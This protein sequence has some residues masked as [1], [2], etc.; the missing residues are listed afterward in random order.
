VTE[1]RGR[2]RNPELLPVTRELVAEVERLSGLPV[3]IEPRAELR[4]KARAAYAVSDPDR[5]RHL[6]LYDPQ[7]ERFLDHMVAHECGHIV[8]YCAASPDDA[9]ILVQNPHDANY[10]RL[11]PELADLIERGMPDRFIQELLPLWLHGSLAQLQNIPADIHIERW[12][13]REFPDLRQ[14]QLDSIGDQADDYLQALAPDVRE[15]TPPSVWLAGNAMNYALLKTMGELFE[16]PEFYEP[17]DEVPKVV[18]LGEILLDEERR[19]EDT[20]LQGDR[21]LTD[22]WARRLGMDTWYA[23]RR[24]DELPTNARRLWDRSSRPRRRQ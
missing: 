13:H 22:R 3:V 18:L 1:R 11:L 14:A 8:R 17:F 10:D 15:M 2:P 20:G 23:W 16:W 9:R 19:L 24:L 4:G 12:L 5:S 6:V 7:F 21:E